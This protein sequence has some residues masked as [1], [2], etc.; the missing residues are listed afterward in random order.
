MALKQAELK[1][2]SN[3]SQAKSVRLDINKLPGASN[4]V[5]SMYVDSSADAN[6]LSNELHE[7]KKMNEKLSNENSRL[8]ATHNADI[9]N[10]QAM[11]LEVTRLKEEMMSA[12]LD[13][14]RAQFSTVVESSEIQRLRK[15]RDQI[16]SVK[17]A[18]EQK[19]DGL[20]IENS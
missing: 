3:N 19:C 1:G 17:Q 13:R 6:K 4:V 8:Q 16:T 20:L 12:S 18:I 2:S 5:H 15:E 11:Q 9:S 10:C 14:S 7:A